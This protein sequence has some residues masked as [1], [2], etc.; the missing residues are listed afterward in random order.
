[1]IK[2]SEGLLIIASDFERRAQQMASYPITKKNL[3]DAVVEYYKSNDVPHYI[4]TMFNKKG[5]EEI[6]PGIIILKE[7]GFGLDIKM[8][9]FMSQKFN[10]EFVV[11]VEKLKS[12]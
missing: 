1:M 6:V 11:K 4:P 9:E 3:Y 2:T 5:Q 7:S 8:S 10:M 12:V